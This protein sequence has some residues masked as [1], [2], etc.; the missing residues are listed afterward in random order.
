MDIQSLIFGLPS[1]LGGISSAEQWEGRRREILKQ[2]EDLFYGRVPTRPTEVWL[3]NISVKGD[4][5]DGLAE[6]RE[7]AAHCFQD[8]QEKT[9]RALLYLPAGACCAGEVPC[10]VGLNFQGNAACTP[11]ADLAVPP[12]PGSRRGEQAHRW[13]FAQIVRAGFAV[14]TAWYGDLFLDEPAG[15]ADSIYKLYYPRKELAA[16]NREL[17]AIAAWAGGYHLLRDIAESEIRVDRR[18]IWAHGHSRLGKA[19]LWAVANHSGFAGVISND[20]GCCGA[21]LSRGTPPGR[22][23]LADITGTFPHWFKPG[24]DAFCGRENALPLD[25]HFLLALAAPRPLLV[26]SAA[27][28]AW[29]APECEFAALL[30]AGE[31]YRLLGETALAADTLYPAP[32]QPCFCGRTG[33]YVR[34]GRHDVLSYDWET[35]LESIRRFA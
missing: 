26:A 18:K 6:R 15:L 11:E 19:A 32:G 31:V 9:V 3:E 24:L 4:A 33:Y 28:D 21:A 20:S 27:E 14:I 13:P 34:G 1:V 22:E 8:G 7:I 10:V 25:Q 12:L 30:A 5:L 16:G 35:A 23:R 17:P 29:A 2:Y